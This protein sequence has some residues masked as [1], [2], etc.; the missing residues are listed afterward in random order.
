MLVCKQKFKP[1]MVLLWHVYIHIDMYCIQKTLIIIWNLLRL[2]PQVIASQQEVSCLYV[3]N[4][5]LRPGIFARQIFEL[6]RKI[7]EYYFVL[8]AVHTN[9]FIS[10]IDNVSDISS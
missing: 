10:L 3:S 6:C 1:Y 8:C 5:P 2:L 4:H 9:T 7:Y